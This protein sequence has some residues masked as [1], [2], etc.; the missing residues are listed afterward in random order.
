MGELPI[1]ITLPD[2]FLD[3][4]IRCG[5][6]VSSKMKAV[7][8]V[9]LDLY[10]ELLRVCDKYNLELFAD[11]GTILGAVRHGGFI[12][13]DDD[14]DFLMSR[15]D[16]DKLCDVAEKEFKEPYF[17]Q[18]EQ[19]SPGIIRGHAQLRNSYTTGCIE[20]DF[21]FNF[22]KGIFIDIFPHDS[23]PED[24]KERERYLLTIGKLIKK[25]RRY[26]SYY[27]GI[28]ESKGIKKIIKNFIIYFY[29]HLSIQYSSKPYIK[30]ENAMKKYEKTNTS[31]W[32]DLFM[33]DYSRLDWNV[34]SK[35]WYD[36]SLDKEFEFLKVKI[37]KGYEEYLS[38]LYGNWKE[39]KIGTSVHGGCIFEPYIPY[40]E[41]CLAERK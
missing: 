11:G 18:T 31:L 12:P 2:G 41:Y 29:K 20:D 14:M 4:E 33:V 5:Y 7:W 15:A 10:K 1:K 25:C 9:E 19:T 32:A 24:K 37:P 21:K 3:E 16:Y 34:K 22:N 38:H 28:N 6:K 27:F 35:K 23:V 36:Y 39:F 40:T 13:W 26:Q 30:W 17:W 8:A